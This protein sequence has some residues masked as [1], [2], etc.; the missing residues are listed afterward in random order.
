MVGPQCAQGTRCAR[1]GLGSCCRPAVVVHA[2]PPFAVP[3]A[4]R[5]SIDQGFPLGAFDIREGCGESTKTAKRG[6]GRIDQNRTTTAL[7]PWPRLPL[8]IAL[9][10]NKGFYGCSSVAQR[11]LYIERAA[12]GAWSTRTE[13]RT[14][15]QRVALLSPPPQSDWQYPPAVLLTAVFFD[16]SPVHFGSIVCCSP[17]P[18]GQNG[19]VLLPPSPPYLSSRCCV[20]LPVVERRKALPYS[21][22]HRTR[23]AK[24]GFRSI[25]ADFGPFL[26]R[27]TYSVETPRTTLGC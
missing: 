5:S 27:Q 4:E 8:S 14:T 17:S 18:P 23:R 21:V 3:T 1:H 24:G 11:L 19:R 15:H 16:P 10:V 6:L 9:V 2:L 26:P 22:Q 20:M 25:F 7:K 13:D 12:A